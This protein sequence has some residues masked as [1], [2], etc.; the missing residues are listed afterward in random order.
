MIMDA[1]KM[2][3]SLDENEF[4]TFDF[5]LFR[6]SQ[7]DP[8]PDNRIQ[9]FLTVGPFVMQTDGSFESEHMYER[10]KI[11]LEDYLSPDGGERN[12]TPSLHKKVKNNYYGSE[13]LQ[14]EK[15]L[16]KWNCLRFDK[17]ED[18][19]DPALFATEQRNAVYYAAFFVNCKRSEMAVISFVNSGC[20]L[21]VNGEEIAFEPYGRVKGLN[22]RGYQCPVT[23]K[24]GKN[25]VL[26]KIRPG[27]IADSMDISMESCLIFPKT[28]ECDGLFTF[29][30][31]K[32]LAYTGTGEEPRMVFPFFAYAKKDTAGAFFEIDGVKSEIPA[33]KKGECCALNA[34]IRVKDKYET[35]KRELTLSNKG[36]RATGDMYFSLIPY[37]GF[38]GNEHI[39]SDF[40]FDTTYHQEQRTY[41]LGAFHIT[42]CIVENLEKKPEFKAI[43]SEIDY[44]HP[45]YSL[46]PHHRETIKKAFEE[47]RAE[48][49]C[50]Y[51]QPNDLT[52]GGEAF[53]R[54]LIYGQLYHRDVMGRVTKMYVPGDVFGH[55]SQLS[56][57][58]K[59]GGCDMIRWA[60]N[61]L[62]V[63]EMFRHIS[64]DGTVMLH[65]KGIIRPNAITLG[66]SSCAHS[67]Q[68]LS[69]FEAYPRTG[70]T[71]WMENTISNA[72][73]SVFSEMAKEMTECVERNIR[74]GRNRLDLTA[75]D[76]TQHHSG[77]LLTR[78]D[79]KIANRL[80]ENLLFSA[81]KMA[82]IAFIYSN[83]YP[84]K[85]LDKA[86]RQLLCAQHHDSITGTNNEISFID[87][88][89]QYRECA[90]IAGDI[91]TT[92]A[93][94]ISSLTENNGEN[95]VTVF[96][97]ASRD[98]AGVCKIDLPKG[99]GGKFFTVK[100]SSGKEYPVHT[101]DG[102]SFFVSGKI[103]ATGYENF[104]VIEKG[105]DPD[106]IKMGSDCTIENACLTLTVSPEKGGGIISLID[107]KTGK[108]F[109]DKN[110][111]ST[112][113]AIYAL[114][115]IHNRMETQH[116]FYTNGQKIC[117]DEDEATVKSEKC[118]AYQRLIIT[119]RLGTIAR[120]IREIT[121]YKG[122]K[123]VDFKTII[124][125]YN[126]ENDLFTAAFPVD[127]KGGAVIFDDRFAPHI[128]TRSKKYM[129]F[130]T[131][132]HL[133]FSGCRVLPANRWF[134]I[135]PSVTVK[136]GENEKIN[137]GMTAII[138]RDEESIKKAADEFTMALAKKGIPVTPYPDTEQHGGN[139][140][141]HFNEDIYET[142]T[143]L[144]LSLSGEEDLYTRKLTGF[145]TA[146]TKAEIKKSLRENG[147]AIVYTKDC[148]N[149]YKKS[150][151]VFLIIGKGIEDIEK[152]GAELSDKL[153]SGYEIYSDK[154]I[155]NA[156]VSP[157]E[158]YGVAIINNGNIA[159]SV[160]GKNTL[161]LML[162]H[163]AAFYGN[164]GKVTGA[165][166]LVPEQKTHIFTYRLYPHKLSFREAGVYYEAQRF[167][168]PLFAIPCEGAR[169]G[170]L[171]E[172]HSFLKAP[173]GF[174]VT[175]LKAGGYPYAS[176]KKDTGSATE[177][178]LTV[179][180]FE[181]DG[182]AK[183]VRLQ[184]GFDI[185]SGFTCDLLDE[186]RQDI[187]VKSK[188]IS[189]NAGAHSI[190]TIGLIPAA[191][192][193][194]RN[195]YP[196]CKDLT[197]PTYV[198]SW[199][200]DMG[201]A[202]TGFLRFAAFLDKKKTE[203]D[204]KTTLININSVNNSTDSPAKVTVKIQCSDGLRA[205]K[206]SVE[207][208]LQ[209]GE[210]CVTPLTVTKSAPGVKGQVKIFYDYD[211]QTF[212]DTY[213][214]G[215]FNPSAELRIENG[216]AICTV[217]NPTDQAL[218]ASLIFVTPVELWGLGNMNPVSFGSSSPLARAVTLEPKSEKEY[219]FEINFDNSSFFKAYYAAVKLCCNG[220]IHFAFAHIH[221]KRHNI[222]AN[223][224]ADEIRND[225]GSV[226]KLMEM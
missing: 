197:E 196:V 151:D 5:D 210:K 204:E 218:D 54:N 47:G 62:G 161:S 31:A 88:M 44:L 7:S 29:S 146:K 125:D 8:E 173:R 140:I 26:F 167:N 50:F 215:Y 65:D 130:Q 177:R 82:A 134:G 28:A 122:A 42:K 175:A 48:A 144:V 90:E 95:T 25:L 24:E 86:L 171:P 136:N 91:L 112:G 115:E 67:S 33:M 109:I 132:Q 214:F 101:R 59:K 85:A 10:E 89:A 83:S 208:R 219:E 195:I 224:M 77:V 181:C 135:G 184:T 37:D 27:Y 34:Q 155:K 137:I 60:K 17:A 113:N 194:Y 133:S 108:E 165:E 225:N 168:E 43:L 156:P 56:Q 6:P 13:F 73:Y 30:P 209:S 55:F 148:D 36:K 182:T 39:F 141:I 128:S 142:D 159:C 45:Y 207:I 118:K 169:G 99:I 4:C 68:A 102:K 22:N 94:Y 216:R 98:S 192:R 166:E 93:K 160:E 92:A 41:A 20:A 220:R 16:I 203:I 38:E 75:R 104:S 74:E 131:H 221:G 206:S 105:T 162:F 14:W 202:P 80:C 76:I 126:S 79:L 200:H 205:D 23:F 96:N 12:I 117:T 190:E 63:D 150:V 40:H 217:K 121:L 185:K 129:S 193:E 154:I 107:K 213:E 97:T 183:R 49:D 111:P 124:E 119:S 120:V 180:G 21:F 72:K 223:E 186:N 152:V 127:I 70:D 164:A 187:P 147:F 172:R 57:V 51:N 61:M 9:D 201:A 19:C 123:T 64:P 69:Y 35:V 52:S 138:R 174:Y 81:E 110:A 222:W 188:S 143:R 87:L 15:G 176:L 211:S 226:K 100:S 1:E 198:R 3:K 170:P 84:E 114:K 53:V 157:A 212:T 32:T 2:Y 189:I 103:P 66:I 153:Q 145:F 199:E 106:P 46:Y 71:K 18:N 11:L 191:E 179:R 158:D 178:G 149:A 116:E 163:T 78:M 58:C 139:K